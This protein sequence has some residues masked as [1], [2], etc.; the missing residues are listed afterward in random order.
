MRVLVTGGAGFIGSHFIRRALQQGRITRLVNL[1]KLTYA[2]HLENLHVFEKDRRY[3]FVKGDIANAPLVEKLVKD[4]DAIIHFAAET[5][6]DRSI[7]DAAPFLHTNVVG[8]YVLLEAAR[9][10]RLRR[11]VHISTDEVYGSVSRGFPTEKA[12]LHPASPYS[13]SKAS[14]DHLALAYH[15]TYGLPVMV[16]RAANNYGPFQYPEKFLPLFI[17]HALENQPLPLYGDGLNVRDWLHVDDHCAALELVLRKGRAGEVYNIATGRGFTN[18]AVADRLIS[19]LAR[20]R[21]LIQYVKDRP[22]HDR[23]YAMSISKIRRE[24]GWSPKIRFEEGLRD[25][26]SWYEDHRSWWETILHGS[27]TYKAHYQKQYGRRKGA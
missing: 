22:G 7:H 25:L 20:P 4:V 16:T 19:M 5:H 26:V 23:R 15:R 17:T 1:D 3:R 6:V 27:K 8:T 11:F 18:K 2:G 13:A 14:S 12:V 21:T 10:A 24:L 9:K